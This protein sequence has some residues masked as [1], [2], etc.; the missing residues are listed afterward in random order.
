MANQGILFINPTI[1]VFDSL[2][3]PA[4]G[5]TITYYKASNHAILKN[6]YQDAAL[7]I[8]WEN[9]IP[10]SSIGQPELRNT[11]IYLDSDEPYYIEFQDQ[12]ANNLND[13]N[14]YP[15]PS[16]LNPITNDQGIQNF[17]PNPSFAFS[18]PIPSLIAATPFQIA[19]GDWWFEKNNQSATDAISFAPFSPGQ[20]FIPGNPIA[21]FAYNCTVGGSAETTKIVYV[22]YYN[23]E[24]FSGSQLSADIY[25]ASETNSEVDLVV[26][27]NFGTGGS[28]QVITNIS[29]FSLSSTN[30]NYTA[31]F[32]VPSIEGLTVGAGSYVLIG[33][34]LPL[35]RVCN[36]QLSPM[37]IYEGE[38][39]IL[40]R[41][42]PQSVIKN[43][44]FASQ[45]PIVNTAMLGLVNPA[46]GEYVQILPKNSF[47][48]IWRAKAG[49]V[50]ILPYSGVDV[51]TLACDGTG[52]WSQ[53]YYN[54]CQ[55]ISTNWGLDSQGF[56][57]S[58]PLCITVTSPK[59]THDI[60]NKSVDIS[61]NLPVFFVADGVTSGPGGYPPTT[62]IFGKSA[63]LIPQS[64]YFF[65]SGTNSP[66]GQTDYYVWFNISS[67]GIDP[68]IAGRTGVEVDLVGNETPSEVNALILAAL[69]AT[70]HFI[71]SA[72]PSNEIISY[73][74]IGGVVS[75]GSDVNTGFAVSQNAGGS[76]F[77]SQI[78]IVFNNATTSL[79]GKYLFLNSTATSYCIYYSLNNQTPPPN[80]SGKKFVKVIFTG[81]ETA[82]Q[83]AALTALQLYNA[84]VVLPTTQGLFIRGW[85]NGNA[86][87]DPDTNARLCIPGSIGGAYGDNIGSYQV[88]Q[89][90]SHLHTYNQATGTAPQSGS[91][92]PCLTTN[93]SQNTGASGGNQSNPNNI[94]MQFVINY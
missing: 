25:M 23:V 31:S 83:L 37:A 15:Y 14:D 19:P 6:I 64:S 11:L 59:F 7:T 58:S 72:I 13:Y 60:I 48:A 34:S 44:C 65:I 29:A 85:A 38:Q 41:E 4:S 77:P 56:L 78:S 80:V 62:C 18:Y 45:Y 30:T 33:I 63:S 93:S 32:T 43:Q 91:A 3:N 70:T 36:F 82:T 50:S 22:K 10:L 39:D 92:T 73:T 79:A 28:D 1:T 49:P 17:V 52:I 2:G 81:S 35:N 21:Q 16:A 71:D 20:T 88:S 9:P 47:T 46:D 69:L 40:Y 84:R 57:S 8:P 27:Q 51:G 53:D 89:N 68:S 74:V 75:P 42:V 5:G 86:T 54:L 87:Y 12:Y 90:L 24:T 55:K 61:S 26:I 67:L 94:Y 66:S 76:D